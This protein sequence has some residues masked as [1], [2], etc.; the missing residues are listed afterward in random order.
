MNKLWQIK[1]LIVNVLYEI[2]TYMYMLTNTKDNNLLYSVR[3][4]N[5]LALWWNNN[6]LFI[7]NNVLNIEMTWVLENLNTHETCNSFAIDKSI[8]SSLLVYRPVSNYLLYFHKWHIVTLTVHHNLIFLYKLFFKF[9][10][11]CNDIHTWF[12]IKK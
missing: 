2:K 4:S 6:R 12:L 10:E 1:I 9:Y 3:M 5:D 7:D 11:H 8:T